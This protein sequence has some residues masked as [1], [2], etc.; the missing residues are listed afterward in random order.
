MANNTKDNLLVQQVREV[1]YWATHESPCSGLPN[2][3]CVL[4]PQVVAMTFSPA[5]GQPV[6]ELCAL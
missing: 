4:V 5:G 3:Q 6:A 2:G 1:S